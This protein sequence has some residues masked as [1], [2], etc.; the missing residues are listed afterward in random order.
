[1]KLSQFSQRSNSTDE[2]EHSRNR[3]RYA[4]TKMNVGLRSAVTGVIIRR[5]RR[6][7]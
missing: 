5:T 4:A 6:P 2:V 3:A 1:M 7:T